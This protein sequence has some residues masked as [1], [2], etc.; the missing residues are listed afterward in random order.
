MDSTDDYE[1]VEAKVHL[2]QPGYHSQNAFYVNKRKYFWSGIRQKINGANFV[3]N[4]YS[5]KVFVRVNETSTE[6]M[7]MQMSVVIRKYSDY[8]SP[9]YGN[10]G[11]VTIDNKDRWFEL[12]FEFNPSEHIGNEPTDDYEFQFYTES[13]QLGAFFVDEIY[14][15]PNAYLVRQHGA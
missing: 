11:S 7:V 8:D 2:V 6:D 4:S 15:V 5:G 1:A 9:R 10:L 13:Q 12:A 14:L 3:A